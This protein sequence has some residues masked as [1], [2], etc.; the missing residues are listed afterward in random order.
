MIAAII[1]HLMMLLWL[2]GLIFGV[3]WVWP[4]FEQMSP[5]YELI[6][7]IIWLSAGAVAWVVAFQIGSAR[8]WRR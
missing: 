6:T 8:F 2:A 4:H 7:A 1:W 3:W 5:T